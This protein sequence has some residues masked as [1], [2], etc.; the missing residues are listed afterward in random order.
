M[1]FIKFFH[2]LVLLPVDTSREQLRSFSS[3]KTT[4]KQGSSLGLSLS[5]C[6]GREV[7]WCPVVGKRVPS[8]TEIDGAAL[9]PCKTWSWAWTSSLMWDGSPDSFLVAATAV[10]GRGLPPR[11]VDTLWL[12]VLLSRLR[13]LLW[14]HHSLLLL[15]VHTW[16]GFSHNTSERIMFCFCFVWPRLV[17]CSILVS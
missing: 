13:P 16:Q 8:F 11:T 10:V 9:C 17:A 3:L 2:S 1:V 12:G 14:W 15:P 5:F 7:S 6:G 4:V